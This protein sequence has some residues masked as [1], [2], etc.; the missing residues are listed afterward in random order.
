MQSALWHVQFVLAYFHTTAEVHELQVQVK[1]L[2][3]LFPNNN[4]NITVRCSLPFAFQLMA[5]VCH[6]KGL[7]PR[8]NYRCGNV[9]IQE[10]KGFSQVCSFVNIVIYNHK[11][12]L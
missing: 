2:S 1:I 5:K 3:F 10:S 9:P 7:E 4:I 11:L 12:G 8:W 6:F